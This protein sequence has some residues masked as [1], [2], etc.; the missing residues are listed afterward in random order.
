MFLIVVH[1]TSMKTFNIL[2]RKS[3]SAVAEMIM[4]EALET[5]EIDECICLYTHY[6]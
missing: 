1:L 5:A 6:F 2:D 3:A 4:T